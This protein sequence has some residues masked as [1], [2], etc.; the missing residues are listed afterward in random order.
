M[1]RSTNLFAGIFGSF[2]VSCIAMILIPNAQIGSIGELVNAEEGTRYPVVNTRPGQET[3]KTEGCYYCHTQQ[4][5]DPQNGSD[6]ERGWGN[7]RTVA[8][9]YMFERPPM[10]G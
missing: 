2:A 8:R 6:I 3:Y 5:R 7:R 1:S 10:L 9:D 4:I